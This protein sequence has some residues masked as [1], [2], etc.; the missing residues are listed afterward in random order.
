MTNFN[1]LQ[2]VMLPKEDFIVDETIIDLSLTKN[3]EGFYQLFNAETTDEKRQVHEIMHTMDTLDFYDQSL[4]DNYPESLNKIT[5]IYALNSLNLA[6]YLMINLIERNQPLPKNALFYLLN[7]YRDY[8]IYTLNIYIEELGSDSY[9]KDYFIE[10]YKKL[11]NIIWKPLEEIYQDKNL[12]KQ[13][14][15]YKYNDQDLE[16]LPFYKFLTP[17][18]QEVDDYNEFKQKLLELG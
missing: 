2:F 13:Y 16:D 12:E 8:N 10:E 11:E 18:R 9:I 6:R 1:L 7:L 5:E 15:H 4:Y 17:L 14:Y 3:L